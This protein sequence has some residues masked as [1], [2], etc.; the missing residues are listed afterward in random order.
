MCHHQQQ[1][2]L[3]P[4]SLPRHLGHVHRGEF[5]LRNPHRVPRRRKVGNAHRRQAVDGNRIRYRLI[6]AMFFNLDDNVALF[7]PSQQRQ[8]EVLRCV[9]YLPGRA[10]HPDVHQLLYAK[11]GLHCRARYP[12]RDHAAQV[13]GH[14]RPVR[15]LLLSRHVLTCRV[16]WV[17]NLFPARVNFN[18]FLCSG[19]SASFSA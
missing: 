9:V 13:R 12:G 18:Y 19:G 14:R 16:I 4:P 15:A 2:G 17:T 5:A 1:A 10:H 8:H 3:N 7:F 11:S 6:I